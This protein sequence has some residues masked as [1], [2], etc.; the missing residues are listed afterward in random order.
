[1]GAMKKGINVSFAP[2]GLSISAGR[3]KAS[4]ESMVGLL[5]QHTWK[6]FHFSWDGIQNLNEVIYISDEGPIKI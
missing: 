3:G 6:T 2:W 5:K 4:R 1:M